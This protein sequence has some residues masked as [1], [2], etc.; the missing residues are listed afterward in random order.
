MREQMSTAAAV[1]ICVNVYV[2][3][4]FILV[5]DFIIAAH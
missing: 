1:F 2:Y 3:V 4:F 5:V